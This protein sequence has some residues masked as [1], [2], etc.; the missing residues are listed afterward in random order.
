MHRIPRLPACLPGLVLLICLALSS[1]AQAQCRGT[2]L[3]EVMPAAERQELMA[4]AAAVPYP[5]GNLWRATRGEAELMLAGTYHLDDPRHDGVMDR[6]LP[7]L[8]RATVLLVEA[9]PEEE[10]ALRD[11]MAAD[12]GTMLAEGGSAVFDRLG[13]E[14]RDRLADALLQRG[15]PGPIAER[16]RPWFL[17]MMLAI[18]PCALPIAARDAGLDKRLIEAADLRGIP[19][20]AL[21]PYDTALRLFDGMTE[22]EQVAMIRNALS[23]EDRAADLLHTTSEAFFTARTRLIWELNRHLSLKQPGADAAEVEAE[24][25]KLEETLMSQRNRDWLAALIDA[26]TKGPAFAAFGA[27]HLPGKAGVLALLEAEGFTLERLPE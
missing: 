13:S 21:E 15:I 6:L 23:F 10:E 7:L 1:A 19:V 18:P 24:F 9:G 11:R 25:A 3:L 22:A 8:E 2:D 4:R 26:A 27:L 20:R 14:E 17:S 12:P 16:L 5:E